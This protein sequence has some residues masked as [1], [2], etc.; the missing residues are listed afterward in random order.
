MATFLTRA[1]N[2][3]APNSGA[4]FA[5]VNTD[6]VHAAGID[7][8][9]AAGITAGCSQEPLRYCPNQPVTRAEMATFL[10][11]ALNLTAPNSGAGF[12]DVP[13]SSA[14]AASIDALR[15]AGITQGCSQ[16]PLR[17]CP[18]QPV[19]RAQMATFLTRALELPVPQ[20]DAGR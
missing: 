4:G 16:E 3:T 6:S 15:A 10:T 9:R 5:D 2:L 19:T 1:L 7:A 12:A 8:L 18:N 17:Y 14:H 11:R 13:E 20:Q